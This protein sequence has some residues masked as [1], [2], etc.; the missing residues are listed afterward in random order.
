MAKRIKKKHR[1]VIRELV[2]LYGPKTVSKEALRSPSRG[3][4]APAFNAG[5]WAGVWVNVELR[6]GALNLQRLDVLPA[7]ELLI[8]D[9]KKYPVR[10]PFASSSRLRAIYKKAAD[11]RS[12]DPGFKE[13]TD[14]AL[15]QI[16]DTLKSY[17]EGAVSIPVR[18]KQ[19]KDMQPVIINAVLS[20]K[21]PLAELPA[22]VI[23]GNRRGIL[24][25]T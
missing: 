21:P 4:G 2:D 13:L 12:T 24:K 8:A 9:E 17:P 16:K 3:A 7:C 15:A 5:T 6:R 23:N 18:V 20:P 19:S 1:Q 11:M 14:A 25:K 22:V 10:R